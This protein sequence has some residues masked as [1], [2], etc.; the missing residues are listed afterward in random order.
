[1]HSKPS[2]LLKFTGLIIVLIGLVGGYI[3]GHYVEPQWEMQ[4]TS[5]DMEQDD[6]GMF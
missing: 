1:M 3:I 2:S 6:S 4:Y 5:L